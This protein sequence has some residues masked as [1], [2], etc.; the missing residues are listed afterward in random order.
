MLAKLA[1]N[2]VQTLF[3]E[4]RYVL[5]LRGLKN[6]VIITVFALLLGVAI[7]LILA[8]I[9]VST[10]NQ[11]WNP[12]R[13]LADLYITVIRGTPIVVQLIIFNGAIMASSKNKILIAVIAFG[14]NSG[15]YVAEIIRSGIQSIDKGQTEA[16][17]SL[18]LTS[19][20]TMRLIVLP[21]AFKTVLPSLGN[22]LI[23]LL[24]ETS[25]SGYVAINDL[26]KAGDSIFSRTYNMTAMY[27][28]ALVYLVLVIGLTALLGRLERRLARNDQR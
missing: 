16:G 26:T 11:K 22:E 21:Q 10:Q 6:T 19:G 18:G 2:L 24:K 7:G 20:M 5:I 17:R 23:A 3:V 8:I 4:Q 27:V 12:L 14:I 25:V 28:V 15:A 9:K 13:W 1:D